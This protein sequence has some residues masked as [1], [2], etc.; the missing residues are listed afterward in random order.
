MPDEMPELV[1]TSDD[2][3]EPADKEPANPTDDA[4]GMEPS[5][6]A[7]VPTDDVDGDELSAKAEA[8]AGSDTRGLWLDT[9]DGR[10]STL[11]P[12]G[13]YSRHI[14]NKAC[15][16]GVFMWLSCFFGLLEYVF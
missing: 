2:E 4:G 16:E 5:A 11:Q 8:T 7:E 9:F 13:L 12:R 10:R 1:D 6:K 15:V 14:D 3:G